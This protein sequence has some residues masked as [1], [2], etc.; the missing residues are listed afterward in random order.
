VGSVSLV[1]TLLGDT[2]F[3]AVEWRENP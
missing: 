1:Y 3:G 2:K